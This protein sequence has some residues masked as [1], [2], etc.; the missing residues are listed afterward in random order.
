MCVCVCVCVC[1]RACVRAGCVSP[2]I[3]VST[4]APIQHVIVQ[5]FVSF[6]VL[7]GKSTGSQVFLFRLGVKLGCSM[8]IT[9][10]DTSRY[11]VHRVSFKS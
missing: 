7:F 11:A 2:L 5:I 10:T 4:C 1:V 8:R 6:L 3:Y 9:D